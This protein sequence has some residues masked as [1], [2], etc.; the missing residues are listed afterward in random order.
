[1]ELETA[2]RI[3]AEGS[4]WV[5]TA[6]EKEFG[7]E[8]LVE[9]SFTKVKTIADAAKMAGYSPDY[10]I[11]R[12]QES[13]DEWAYR[14]LKMATKAINQGWVPDPSNKKQPKWYNWFEIDSSGA[15]FSNSYSDYDYVGTCLGSR[16]C[17][18]NAEKAK[19]VREQFEELY[20][21]FLL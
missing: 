15:G 5:K 10:L 16:L 17:F 14:M 18:E 20:V 3:Y 9:K 11:L 2:K 4:G 13:A 7:K 1:M 21:K 6:L 8:N 19:F 12:D